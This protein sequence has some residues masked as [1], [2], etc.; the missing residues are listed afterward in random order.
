MRDLKE[1]PRQ[2]AEK[3]R[4]DPLGSD[5][6]GFVRD[7]AILL[8]LGTSLALAS[9]AWLLV[10]PLLNAQQPAPPPLD[11]PEAVEPQSSISAHR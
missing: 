11:R 1:E 5:S 2:G 8:I 6:G 7:V 10:G 4:P 9:A 3:P